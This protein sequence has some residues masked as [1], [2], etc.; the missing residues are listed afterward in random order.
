MHP[1]PVHRSRILMGCVGEKCRA[2]AAGLEEKMTLARW[3][4][5]ASVSGL[6]ALVRNDGVFW[7]CEVVLGVLT[8]G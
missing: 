4:V 6:G 2:L 8:S 5:E 1:V 3:R 7:R